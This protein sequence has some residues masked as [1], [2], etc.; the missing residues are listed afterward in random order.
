M[1]FYQSSAHILVKGHGQLFKIQTPAVWGI[2]RLDK[3]WLV[4]YMFV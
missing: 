2:L 3:G 4:I 1:F